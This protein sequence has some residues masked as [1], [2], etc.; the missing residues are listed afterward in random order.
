MRVRLVPTFGEKVASLVDK[1]KHV[2]FDFDY[3]TVLL[4]LD[5]DE[6]DIDDAVD[7]A[8]TL[9]AINLHAP[10][11]LHAV[12]HVVNLPIILSAEEYTNAVTKA[13]EKTADRFASSARFK[14]HP[15]A[16][17]L[18]TQC[19]NGVRDLCHKSIQRV[20]ILPPARVAYRTAHRIA[21]R[22]RKQF[23]QYAAQAFP[24]NGYMFVR[25][26][27]IP[28]QL[29]LCWV[30]VLRRRMVRYL[31][32]TANFTRLDEPDD[33][34][35]TSLS[36]FIFTFLRRCD[37]TVPDITW[38]AWIFDLLA[39][40]LDRDKPKGGSRPVCNNQTVVTTL[41]DKLCACLTTACLSL[42]SAHVRSCQ[43]D[44]GS[45]LKMHLHM[46]WS[47]GNIQHFIDMV[48]TQPIHGI[49]HYDDTLIP[50]S[51]ANIRER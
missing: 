47:I 19:L 14:E 41:L 46:V 33:Y 27:K 1:S 42:I 31:S 40:V 36:D 18:V 30:R 32:D 24:F 3:D 44:I 11:L 51:T 7:I 28:D 4:S 2:C 13:F 29:K 48:P 43:E 25:Q 23:D 26:D 22:L 5:D 10:N 45:K 20:S 35:L 8:N 6:P 50:T 12:E 37:H 17:T 38:D 49:Q 15:A 9:R 21:T 34:V 39:R 16:I